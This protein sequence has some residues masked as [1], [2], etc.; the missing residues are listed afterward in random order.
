MAYLFPHTTFPPQIEETLLELFDELIVLQPIMDDLK[1]S[2]EQ[3][4]PNRRLK[5][6]CPFET[7]HEQ[8]NQLVSAY[9]KWAEQYGGADLQQVKS[10]LDATHFFDDESS[11]QLE[12]MIRPSEEPT[13][14]QENV[15]LKQELLNSRVF[16]SL[17]QVFDLRN[18]EMEANLVQVK[19]TEAHLFAQL[20]GNQSEI[21]SHAK[22]GDGSQGSYMIRERMAAWSLF[23]TQLEV[24]PNILVT[25]SP[26]VK[27][28]IE[29]VVPS[30]DLFCMEGWVILS[31]DESQRLQWREGFLTVL[32]HWLVAPAKVQDLSE[33]LLDK[34]PAGQK[35]VHIAVYRI[36]QCNLTRC[37]NGPEQM[38]DQMNPQNSVVVLVQ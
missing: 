16:L 21:A 8:V 26:E 32:D 38:W 25:L 24:I 7:G 6:Q 20:H 30:K 27:P 14:L 9:T 13:K 15:D 31:D 28:L 2:L 33:L 17:A 5:F 11:F 19:A 12:S 22:W 18:W 29:E 35:S 36:R 34:E 3:N 4:E 10:Q 37:L 1:P 23:L